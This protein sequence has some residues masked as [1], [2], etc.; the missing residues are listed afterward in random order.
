MANFPHGC[1]SG[2][3][4]ESLFNSFFDQWFPRLYAS[5]RSQGVEE[6]AAEDLA[7]DTLMSLFRQAKKQPID[8]YEK[9]LWGIYKN[10]LNLYWRKKKSRN[11]QPLVADGRLLVED[12]KDDGLNVTEALQLLNKLTMHSNKRVA[13]GAR[14]LIEQLRGRKIEEIATQYGVPQGTVKSSTHKARSVLQ[15]ASKSESQGAV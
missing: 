4:L 14:F 12:V 7:Q 3:G 8:D 9:Y 1:S 13:Q 6:H 2:P 5:A 11:E 15:Q 10:L